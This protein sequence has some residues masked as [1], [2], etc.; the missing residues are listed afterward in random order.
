MRIASFVKC[1]LLALVSAS[2]WAGVQAT[3]PALTAPGKQ[4]ATQFYLEYRAAYDKAAKFD[5]IL[6]F[7]AAAKRT[8]AEAMPA[9]VRGQGFQVLKST[10]P[11][12]SVTVLK[13]ENT[14]DGAKLTVEGVRSDNKKRAGI[15]T[16][17]KEGGAWKV[18]AEHW[19]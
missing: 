18:A 10:N 3:K 2:V 15:V 6:P 4:T 12:T 7:W 8:E 9:L 14:I 16:I 13:E 5:D 17:V 1:F 19:S 11:L